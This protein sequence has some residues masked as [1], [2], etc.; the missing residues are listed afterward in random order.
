MLGFIPKNTI[1]IISPLFDLEKFKPLLKDPVSHVGWYRSVEGTYQDQ[2]LTVI[3]TIPGAG[4]NGDLALALKDLAKKIIFVGAAGA[5]NKELHLGDYFAATTAY[6][7]ESFSDYFNNEIDIEKILKNKIPVNFKQKFS[8]PSG[9]AYTCGSLLAEN[10]E[11]LI[12]LQKKNIDVIDMETSALYT[13][14]KI[15]GI[16]TIAVYFISDKPLEKNLFTEYSAE[17][18]KRLASSKKDFIKFVLDNFLK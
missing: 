17:E 16:E 8:C 5:L 12:K 18:K 7:G 2:P 10:D 15:T 4:S 9:Q 14:A 13:S 11:L 6:N 3:K 1:I